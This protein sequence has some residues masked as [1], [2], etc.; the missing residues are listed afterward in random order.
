MPATILNG[1]TTSSSGLNINLSLLVGAIITALVVA[2]TVATIIL[3][4][5]GVG[6]SSPQPQPDFATTYKRVPITVDVLI[7]D[8][9]PRG[10]NLTLTQ[11]VDQPKYGT[12]KILS[13][14]QVVY[15]SIGSFSGND[16][17]SYEVSNS[18]VTA[19]ATVTVQ[20]LN[21]PPQAVPIY[22]KISKNAN[23]ALVDIFNY[24]GDN[25]E[26]IT[27][28]DNDV[29]YVTGFADQQVTSGNAQSLGAIEIDPYNGFLY[30]PVNGFNGIEQFKYTISDGNDT[31]SSTVTVEVEN[32]APVATDDVYRIPKYSSLELLILQNDYD[33]NGDDF[34]V[35]N[36]VGA[37]YG[38]LRVQD[39]TVVYFTSSVLTKKY[40]D[41]FEYSI[42]DSQASGSAVVSV[43]VYNTE[44][45]VYSKTVTVGKSSSNNLISIDYS[46]PDGKDVVVL[47]KVTPALASLNPAASMQ[48]AKGTKRVNLDCCDW[49]SVETNNYTIV[50]TPTP[51]VVYSQTL[52]IS[53][54]DGESDGYGKITINVVNNPPVAVD[55][56]VTCNK[57]QQVL[58]NVLANDYD[59][60]PGDTE[61]LQLTNNGWQ[62]TTKNGGSVSIYNATH[63]LYVAPKG[64]L[65]T[66][67]ASYRIYDQSKD[68]QGNPDSTGFSTGKISINIINNPPVPV[69]DVFTISKGLNATLNVL[70]N[71]YD[72][73]F[74]L[75]STINSVDRSTVK[76]IL[77]TI[78][79]IYQ[80]PS[81][82]VVE[83]IS[84]SVRYTPNTAFVG[85]DTFQYK[86]NDGIFDSQTVKF[87]STQTSATVGT[88][89]IKYTVSDGNKNTI[90]NVNVLVTNTKPVAFADAYTYHWAAPKQTLS[91]M[92]NDKDADLDPIS[93]KSVSGSAAAVKNGNDIDY[94]PKKDVVYGK[95]NSPV[96]VSLANV[97]SDI[98]TLDIPYVA[99]NGVISNV[100][101]GSTSLSGTTVT[102]TPSV[103][104]LVFTQISGNLYNA[105][106]SFKFQ[107]FD[108]ISTSTGNVTI[109][110]SNNA[111]TGTGKTVNIARDYT[112]T[113]YDFTWSEIAT[114]ANPD[115]DGDSVTIT[116]LVSVDSSI[117]VEQT[118]SGTKQI[119]FYLY[120]GLHYSISK[121]TFTVIFSNSAPTC[122]VVS[123]IYLNKKGS[124]DLS[125]K[126]SGTDS[127]NDPITFTLS[128][129]PGSLGTLSG[130]VFTA[131]AT[132]TGTVTF[133]YT[134]TDTQLTSSS[135]SIQIII[136]NANPSANDTIF[137]IY[138]TADSLSHY[139]S[140]KATDADGDTLTYTAGSNNCSS[141]S[142]GV[143]MNSASGLITFKRIY[144]VVSGTC[145]MSVSVSD[146][147]TPSGKSNATITF[148]IVPI[149]PVARDDRFSIPQGQTI[150]I[151]ASQILANDNDE[152]GTSSTLT[153]LNISCPDATYCHKQPR[154]VTV[155]DE[156]AVEVDS[157]QNTCQAD[158]FR[159]T[160]TTA[161]GAIRSADVYIEFKNC[162]CTA[163]LDF[164][165]LLDS[166]QSIGVPN[167]NLIRDLCQRITGRMKL[168]DDAVKVSI[169]RFHSS[170]TLTLALSTDGSLINKTL[171][172]MKYDAGF[173]AQVP[174]L[175]AAV[176]ALRPENGGRADADKVIYILTD[177][178]ANV[179]CDCSSCESEW[180][181]IPSVFKDS[182]QNKIINGMTNPAKSTA[183]RNMCKYQYN[184]GSELVGTDCSSCSMKDEY[185]CLPCSDAIPVA[186]KINTWKRNSNGVVPNDPD[187]PY[188]G[189]NKVQ[190]KV[191]A[192]AVGD[193]MTNV[194]GSRQIEGM[195][196]DS[197]RA[198]TVS[199]TDLSGT[200]SEIVDQSCNQVNV[201]VPV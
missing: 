1:S 136:Q 152:L 96:S 197:T 78:I 118:V 66:D 146:S 145:K 194:W 75:I 12:V 193:A 76:N 91:V 35:T 154:F 30:T 101:G 15:Q 11:I 29:L 125:T 135:C 44:P 183:L 132:N 147:N 8:N 53:M 67:V 48:V 173:T 168:A 55:D 104:S 46:D 57:N 127:N 31:A 140:Y 138:P 62:S 107:C 3:V 195:N 142:T 36:A 64:S 41:S 80:N 43:Q 79:E 143:S 167:F 93:I 45:T 23:K 105:T 25:D 139:L 187:N 199:W 7:N 176:N 170:A 34:N 196:Y 113:T 110:L 151:F 83:V 99:F 54:T 32:D 69:D 33:I 18:F 165:F 103:T 65:A 68:V 14:S 190:W 60:N 56:T 24:I 155:N 19:N 98:D 161:L 178:L 122:G 111:P 129:S 37:G 70:N 185:M 50:Y 137:Y 59:V 4:S 130:K 95:W 40:T 120:D 121:L 117:T 201:Q 22:K 162:Y 119:T 157:D 27:D 13:R 9:D 38:A 131:S 77:A 115:V 180:G 63:V 163:K 159:Y 73:N 124:V 108:G 175:R 85:V 94:T 126:F 51:G 102:F 191:V 134:A 5:V 181:T 166:S 97:C 6:Y 184:D 49:V 20:V 74:D 84:D 87:V 71:D 42:S 47:T 164:V 133:S 89:Q 123:T 144:T 192:M 179:P 186:A 58:I 92:S 39:K 86:L 128:G 52:D 141:I 182:V 116:N 160:M 81:N 148:V 174:G 198:I 61:L 100:A 188:N 149:D 90:G 26:K 150:R 169:V 172:T 88:K 72:P 153:L 106:A 177:G 28:I 109:I 114:Y 200:M 189:N 156:I 2:S 10:G 16:T 171:S 82:G 21:R 17:F 158:K 112:K